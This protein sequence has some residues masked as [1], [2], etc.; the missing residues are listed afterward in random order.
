MK[1]Y[2]A[3]PWLERDRLPA[4]ARVFEAAGH[5]LTERWWEHPD[6]PGYP[7]NTT[8]AEDKELA[9]QAIKDFMGVLL[10]EAVVV[11]NSAKS[12]GKA[13]ETGVAIAA[14]MPVIVVG[15]RSNIFHW[16]LP[17]EF[18]VDTIDEALRLL[19]SF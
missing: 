1:V 3:A 5:T 6:V 7:H 2:L 17:P 15:Q 10:A 13:V 9:D 11:I 19:S 12:E 14:N 8:E 4:Y 18:C 16:M